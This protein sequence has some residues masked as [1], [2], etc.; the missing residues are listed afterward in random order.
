MLAGPTGSLD[1]GRSWSR[2]GNS[3]SNPFLRR[4]LP[5][6][7]RGP[8]AGSS[9]TGAPMDGGPP[10]DRDRF[11]PGLRTD[12]GR[13]GVG[14]RAR[15]A[16]GGGGRRRGPIPSPDGARGDSSESDAHVRGR[17]LARPDRDPLGHSG[18]R[19][20]PGEPWRQV[21]GKSSTGP[22]GRRRRLVAGRGR[23]RP[24]R[25]SGGRS[26]GPT[27][28]TRRIPTGAS[29]TLPTAPPASGSTWLVWPRPSASTASS[30]PAWRR[31]DGS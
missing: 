14:G 31:P 9:A 3:C 27:R 5:F 4:G 22:G 6:H 17:A 19:L 18:H 30:R 13:R 11:S 12:D 28:P 26:D 15:R 2:L 23:G 21:P 29:P 10:R 7:R 16:G 1:R 25:G 8:L 20:P 24:P